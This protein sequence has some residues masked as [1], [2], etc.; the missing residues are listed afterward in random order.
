[1]IRPLLRRFTELYVRTGRWPGRLLR[2]LLAAGPRRPAGRPARLWLEPLEERALPSVNF[3]AQA[4]ISIGTYTVDQVMVDV[5]GDGKPDLIAAGDGTNGNMLAVLLNTTGTGAPT[6][7]FAAKQDFTAGNPFSGAT[8]A[9]VNGDGKPDLIAADDGNNAVEVLL[10]TT[11]KGAS[12]ASF[13]AP[14]T[15]AA[16]YRPKTVVTADVNGDGKPDL[17]AADA[18]SNS[19]SVLLNMTTTGAKT[20]SFAAHQDFAAGSYSWIVTAA[21]VN[22]DGRPDVIAA[23]SL[24][25]SV[26][27][28][29]NTTPAGS[30]VPSFAAHQ[31]FVVSGGP[32]GLAASDVN[33][34]GR[35]DLVALNLETHSI[36]V[37]LNVTPAGAPSPSF[38][39]RQDFLVGVNDASALAV[40]DIDGDGRPDVVTG[41]G[42]DKM[43]S[44][45]VNTTAAGAAAASFAA[46]RTFATSDSNFGPV[47]TADV[48]G[49]GKI[50]V[51]DGLNSG[52]VAVFMNTSSGPTDPAK[53]SLTTNPGNSTAG[54]PSI[55]ALEARNAAGVVET[56]GGDV[57]TF[58]LGNSAGARGYFGP[59]IDNGNGTYSTTFFPTG[60]GTNVLIATDNGVQVPNYLFHTVY[61]G[62]ADA[63]TSVVTVARGAVAFGGTTAVTLRARDRY[64]NDETSGGETVTFSASGSG[65]GTFGATTD[66]HNGT[67]TATFTATAAG[68][69]TITGTIKGIS[70]S[71]PAPAVVIA[72]K[73]NFDTA[74][75]AGAGVWQYSQ[76]AG[77]WTQLSPTDAAALAANQ[78]GRV[79]AV[80]RGQ[81]VWTHVPG[82]TWKQVSAS[83]ASALGITSSGDVTCAFPGQGVWTYT[84]ATASWAQLTAA[85]TALLAE[86]S[87]G[88]IV[89]DFRGSGVWL[90][91]P[92]A[93]WAQLT[94][95]EASLLTISS[96]GGVVV[97]DFAGQGVWRYQAG[98]GWKQ[99]AA[100]DATAVA[101]DAGGDAAASFG[102]AGLFSYTD[103]GGWASLGGAAGPLALDAAGDVVADFGGSGLWRFE[104]AGGWKQLNAGHAYLLAVG[105]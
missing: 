72:G 8:A 99:L 49:D 91:A 59:V 13:A 94:G 102:G 103:A 88:K 74:D 47:L 16:G 38:A 41:N 84:N 76:S 4:A 81:G 66:N 2:T 57:V 105:G 23:N 77:T 61:P 36:S 33:G 3:A 70:L 73:S 60:A 19:V 34:D 10:N 21:D 30:P 9:D 64:G 26:S 92:G 80:F 37:L 98:V 83:D 71:T 6:P 46:Q 35:P 75:F 12:V 55:V 28:L 87:F 5:N 67:Y 1:M 17:I 96:S 69:V 97:G 50:D 11:A 31:D 42:T 45:L 65:Q 95:G 79:A 51:L 104:Q 63:Y 53:S 14:L 62:P 78:F 56:A 93:G 24:D 52:S 18:D 39:A 68:T 54:T 86:D 40:A 101:V 58:A 43:V 90:Y 22:G 82:N 27:V 15:F 25:H 85:D 100:T 29:L 7:S 20:P 48:N 32:Y 89:A 44:V